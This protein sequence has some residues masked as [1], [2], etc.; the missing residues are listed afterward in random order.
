MKKVKF[1]RIEPVDT[2]NRARPIVFNFYVSD[3]FGPEKTLAAGGMHTASID[4]EGR[5]SAWGPNTYC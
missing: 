1:F 4:A 3:G 2:Q 5:I